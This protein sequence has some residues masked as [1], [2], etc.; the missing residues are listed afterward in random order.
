MSQP[1]QPSPPSPPPPP[2]SQELTVFI[3]YGREDI[4]NKFAEKLHRDLTTNGY[5]CI[6]DVED[7]LAGDSLSEVI[8]NKIAGCD[9]FI[10]ILSQKYSQS[11][12]CCNELI[13]ADDQKKK[14]L[15]IKRQ[16]ECDISHQ[17]KLLLKDRV[18]L[19][20]IS[21]EEYDENLTKLIRALEEVA[22][23]NCTVKL[24]VIYCNFCSFSTREN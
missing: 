1:T 19:S 20:F 7:F 3:S 11:K 13:Y 14:L 16:E 17:V 21:D 6:R 12:W 10:V 5:K 8:A 2:T 23:C 9:A 4:T 22:I 18:Y 15:V 24:V